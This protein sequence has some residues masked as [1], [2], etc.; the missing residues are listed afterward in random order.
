VLF[1]ARQGLLRRFSPSR[2]QGLNLVC[3]LL[4]KLQSQ[5][6]LSLWRGDKRQARIFCRQLE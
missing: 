4:D 1:Q 2:G 5:V 3:P 6:Y